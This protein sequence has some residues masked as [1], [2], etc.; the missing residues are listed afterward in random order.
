MFAHLAVPLD[1]SSLA[2]CVLPHVVTFAQAFNARVTLLQVLN[3]GCNDGS[4]GIVDPVAWEMQKAEA[5]AYLGAT[6][7]ALEAANL[8][9]DCQLLEGEPARSIVDFAGSAGADLIIL[10][11]HGQSGLSFWN[12]SSVVS[13]VIRRSTVATLVVRAYQPVTSTLHGQCYRRILVP[14][15]GSQRAECVVPAVTPLARTCEALVLL[16]HV[17]Y[18]PEMP[19]RYPLTQDDLELTAKFV[20]RNQEVAAKYLKQLQSYG[21]DNADTRLILGE[22]VI[23]G[24]HSM[25]EVEG[26]DLVV[27]SAHGYSGNPRRR[28]GSVTT[29]FIEYDSAPLLVVQDLAPEELQPIEAKIVAREGQGH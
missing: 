5:A 27:L 20:E 29:D 28:Y 14:L 8:L 12:V 13:K 26:V 3:N 6:A 15:D 7:Q 21:F 16:S 4:R 10:S 24:L 9:V 11:S 2:E 19:H 17:V 25:V 22:N 18:K 1:G 23:E